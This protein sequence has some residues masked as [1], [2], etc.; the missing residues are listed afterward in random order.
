MVLLIYYKFTIYTGR[1][2]GI[3][4]KI[5]VIKRKAYGF[6]DVEYFFLIIKDLFSFSN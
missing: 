2:E 5:K 3:N 6:N 1:I 4:N